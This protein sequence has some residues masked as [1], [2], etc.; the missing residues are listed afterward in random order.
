MLSVSFAPATSVI[1]GNAPFAVVVSDFNGDGKSDLATAN[2]YAES[3]S[4]LTN[5]TVFLTFSR[6]SITYGES[7][8]L[9]ASVPAGATGAV[10]FLDGSAELGTA[11]VNAE[12][13][14]ALTSMGLDA[15]IHRIV[16]TFV[17]D[18]SSATSSSSAMDLT[19]KKANQTITW[20]TPAATTSGT[21]LGATQ[22]NATV[23]GVLMGS[24]PGTLTYSPAA[25]TVL[26]AGKRTLKVT[27]AATANYNAASR[28]VV[29]T[30][31][32]NVAPTNIR[33]S[34]ATVAENQAP[35]KVVGTLSTVDAN[36]GD[37]FTYRLVSGTGSTNNASFAIIGNQLQTRV[38]F[39]FEV[40]KSYSIRVR[41][42]DRGGRY[43]EK[44]FTISVTNINES[45]KGVKISASTIGENKPVGTVVGTLSGV[46]P[47]SGNTFTYSLTDDAGHLL[48]AEG[49]MFTIVGNQLKTAA[50]FNYELGIPTYRLG[51]QI[52]D[53]G[54]LSFISSLVINVTN[55]NEAPTGVGLS[56]TTV[57]EN[58]AAGTLVGTLSTT[59][60]DAGNTF[61]YTLVPGTG[62]ADNAAFSIPLGTRQ[63]KTTRAF[64]Y[65]KKKSYAIRIRSTDQGGLFCEKAI[66]INV[67]DVDE[68]PAVKTGA[69]SL[70]LKGD[71]NLSD[72]DG[73]T[74]ATSTA[75]AVLTTS[76]GTD[77]QLAAENGMTFP[78]T[79][80]GSLLSLDPQPFTSST[81]RTLNM[82]LFSGG[83]VGAFV[84][85]GQELDDAQDLSIQVSTWAPAVTTSILPSQ[86]AGN[87]QMK[88]VSDSDLRS[89]PTEAF[90]VT[91]QTWQVVDRGNGSI[92][93]DGLPM[94]ISGNRLLP[95]AVPGFTTYYSCV[96][97]GKTLALATYTA[98]DQGVYSVTVA[99]GYRL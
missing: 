32:S 95:L 35:G 49:G 83:S 65:E 18:S 3:A 28:S 9:T 80:S 61:R 16:A 23:A 78:L 91:S 25:G 8:V 10:H 75:A 88:I 52:K 4:V 46:D 93:V 26:A 12:G 42:S 1:A 89:Q 17:A 34:K 84:M 82:Y 56:S 29:L 67:G 94:A 50:R 41:A 45:P 73:L 57:L 20:K 19:V 53:Q 85:M 72:S 51:I 15:G 54:G 68:S 60:A 21:K 96:T 64:N 5:T 87:W 39:N 55:V 14:A 98:N 63:L 40:K 69:Y 70:T 6:P 90:T 33:L 92:D 37:T 79:R 38:P 43:F 76:N 59:D 58:K 22:L 81:F 99:M 44:A 31:V 13:K 97:D 2:E 24:A 71:D 74:V 30:V 86:L 36:A 77:Y 11:V 66:T 62:S 48:S 47:D 7:V 27:A